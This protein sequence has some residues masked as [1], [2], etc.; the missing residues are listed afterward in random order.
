[1]KNKFLIVTLILLFVLITPLYVVRSDPLNNLPPDCEIV[2][3]TPN[4][5]VQEEVVTLVGKAMDPED[6]VKLFYWDCNGDGIW[7]VLG[8]QVSGSGWVYH[9]TYYNYSVPSDCNS[10]NYSVILR[11]YDNAGDYDTDTDT[12]TVTAYPV[13]NADGPYFGNIHEPLTINGSKS[14]DPNG[15][16]TVWEWD[17]GDGNFGY[18]E[19]TNHSYSMSGNYSVTLTVTDNL[20]AQDSDI[21]L[22]TIN[23]PPNEP[24]ITGPQYGKINTEYTFSLSPITDPDGDQLYC[25]WDWGNGNNS[26][27]LGPFNS[28]ATTNVSYAWSKPGNY[29]I[30]VKLKDSYGAESNWSEPFVIQIVELKTAFFLGTYLGTFESPEDIIVLQAGFFVVI[31]SDSTIYQGRIIVIARDYLGLQGSLFILGVGGIAII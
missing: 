19:I 25:L 5:A 11:V 23:A 10:Y 3:I 27:W 14:Y 30:K 20:G 4:P 12:I 17:F 22:T 18:G 31:P 8:E 7:E 2:S 1:M 24:T 29:S 16:I 9:T 28:G 21:T 6:G 26:G 13:A 15:N